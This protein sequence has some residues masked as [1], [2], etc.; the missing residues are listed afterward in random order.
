MRDFSPRTATEHEAASA[1]D[2][3]V[4]AVAPAVEQL[5]P[6]EDDVAVGE[7]AGLVEA[8]DI[9]AREALD[10]RQL[11]NQRLLACERDRS[12]RERQ[13]R[14][15]DQPFRHHADQRG[16][17]AGD[18]GLP[19]LV[20]RGVEQAPQQKRCDDLSMRFLVLA[21]CLRRLPSAALTTDFLSATNAAMSP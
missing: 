7:G 11:L 2:G 15:Q 21:M 8:D 9:H 12:D 13:A 3:G 16:D 10:R 17:G 4:V 19:A 14:Q 18:G 5:Q 6:V 20:V 1:A